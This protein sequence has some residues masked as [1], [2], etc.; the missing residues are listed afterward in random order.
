MNHSMTRKMFALL[1]AVML[2][3]A[4]LPAAVFAADASSV[5]VKLTSGK[6]TVSINGKPTVVQAP[7]VASN[8]TM[9]PL[10][11]ITN[12]FGAALKL[13]NGNGITLT[14]NDRKVELTFGSKTVKVNGVA[15]T[16]AVAPVVIKGTT[17]VPLRVIVEAFGAKIT[18]DKKTSEVTIKGERA[19]STG[20]GSTS[21]D[22]DYGKTKVGDSYQD[23]SLNY[24]AALVQVDQSDNGSFVRWA[25]A[26]ED[27]QVIIMTESIGDELTSS[28]L[29]EE[30]SLYYDY[31]EYSLDERT[32][33]VGDYSFE[34]IITRSKDSQMFY[35]YRGIQKGET[36]Y[37]IIVGVKATDKS[38]L[39]AY[40]NLL[41]SFKPSFDKADKALKDITKV[42]DGFIS[43]VDEDYGFSVKL[44]ADWYYD[45]EGEEPYFIGEDDDLQYSFTSLE[46]GDSLEKWAARNES[47]L[48]GD[49]VSG[50]LRNVSSAPIKLQDG[51]AIVLSYEM[52]FDQKDW[53]AYKE[54]MFVSG[55]YKYLITYSYDAKTAA[56]ST[57]S[58]NRIIGSVDIDTAYIDK[59]FGYKED[60][61]TSAGNRDEKVT[62]R[63]T[64]YGYSIEL[65]AFWYGYAKDFNDTSVF[66]SYQGG[67]LQIEFDEESKAADLEEML[68][69]YVDS[70]EGEEMG[71][72]I[73][74]N[75]NVTINGK[76]AHKFVIHSDGGN[77]DIA[78]T[79]YTYVFDTPKGAMIYT[80]SINGANAT[81]SNMKRIE[82][83]V[84]S[85]RFN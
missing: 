25:D 66:Y 50:Y 37:I 26:K 47:T 5:E 24:P 77:F 14:Y 34:K 7:Y 11:I 8:T 64:E 78:Y 59:N 27:A 43:Y 71:L 35:E 79:E 15:K 48:K 81:E 73:K 44:P 53:F 4:L 70:E 68:Q 19:Q 56:T 67:S 3:I 23:W 22:S 30:L 54:V 62:K 82:E 2:V 1:M 52:S 49:F 32:I 38:A 60:T 57:Q 46:E 16:V 18:I 72:E 83:A 63:S 69:L 20:G 85:I 36:F 76:S 61:S 80:F 28:E 74:E 39:N 42:K 13:E 6:A 29:R 12:A 21:I 84:Q 51:N 10:K 17:M 75:T 58:F 65:P 41:D 55:S 40:Q 31:D 45:S 33:K 9:V